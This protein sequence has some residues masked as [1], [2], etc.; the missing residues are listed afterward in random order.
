MSPYLRPLLRL[1]VVFL[2]SSFPQS[3]MENDSTFT[4]QLFGSVVRTPVQRREL[5]AEGAV[6]VAGVDCLLFLLF[7]LDIF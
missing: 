4:S 6:A 1:K 2:T 5:S 7:L 3:D